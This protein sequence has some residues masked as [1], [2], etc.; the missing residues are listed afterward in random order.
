MREKRKSNS[1]KVLLRLLPGTVRPA[2]L[3]FL[4]FIVIYFR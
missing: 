1:V 2:P 3:L 4:V